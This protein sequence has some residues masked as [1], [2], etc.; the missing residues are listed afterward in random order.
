MNAAPRPALPDYPF[1]SHFF[2]HESGFRQHYVD[3]GSGAPVLMIHGNPT[4]S[5]FFRRLISG[6]ADQARV[7]A[8]DHIGMGLSDKPADGAYG[9]RLGDRVDDLEALYR[10]F[11]AERGLP[12]RGWTLVVHDW[13]GM[14]GLAW[15]ARHPERIAKL[16]VLNTAAFPNPKGM[17]LPAAL[18]LGRDSAFGGW[19]TSR[20]NAFA[21]GA[22]RFATMRPLPADVRAAYLAPYDTPAHRLA[23][24]KF[25]E[26]IP[27][28]RDDPS[29]ALVA[30]TAERLATF[31]DRPMAIHWGR[32]DFVFDDAFLAEWQRRFPNAEVHAYADAG[33]Y[34]LDDAWERI[35]PSVRAFLRRS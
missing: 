22:T 28:T 16:V 29:Y 5:Y 14:I 34:V 10:H 21:W 35:V 8:P 12:E 17:R 26:D 3:V 6:L 32:R 25:V 33:H 18:K 9:F 31:N 2:A 1:A 13:G 23:T 15:A 20:F 7:L 24:R 11:V 19:L 27:L 30:K 4:W